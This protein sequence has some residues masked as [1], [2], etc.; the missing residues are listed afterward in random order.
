MDV[1]PT[2]EVYESVMKT[3]PKPTTVQHPAAAFLEEYMERHLRMAL[4][5]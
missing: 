2:E 5:V 4:L 1:D 3:A